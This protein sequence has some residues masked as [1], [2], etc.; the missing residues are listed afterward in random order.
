MSRRAPR[1]RLVVSIFVALALG[2]YCMW[3]FAHYEGYFD[4]PVPTLHWLAGR[5]AVPSAIITLYTV[6]SVNVPLESVFRPGPTMSLLWDGAVGLIYLQF[7]LLL[8]SL[9]WFVLIYFPTNGILRLIARRTHAA[10]V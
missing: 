5:V 10:E 9:Q 4:A 6:A 8:C 7:W 1:V 3:A 2:G